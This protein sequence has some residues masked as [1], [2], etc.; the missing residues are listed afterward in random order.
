M[1][2]YAVVDHWVKPADGE[3]ENG[4]GTERTGAYEGGLDGR[5]LMVSTLNLPFLESQHLVNV[6]LAPA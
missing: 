5:K 4:V 2:V 3:S 1:S 6:T